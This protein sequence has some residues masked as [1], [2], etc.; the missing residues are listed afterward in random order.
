V[1]HYAL[2]VA[3]QIVAFCLSALAGRT[4]FYWW[5]R[6]GEQDRARVWRLYGWFSALMMFGCC[7]GALNWAS[8]IMFQENI[9]KGDDTSY[10]SNQVE[11]LTL[12][13]LAHRWRAANHMM[14]AIEFLCLCAAE[15][16]VLDRM[17]VFAAPGDV[18][19]QKRWAAAGRVVMAVAVLGNAVG[20]AANA[21]AAVHLQKA[22]AAESTAASYFAANNTDKGNESSSSASKELQLGGSFA[23]VQRF[24]EFAVLLLIV[25]AFVVVGVLC[26]RRVKSRLLGVDAASAAAA[27]GRAL[28]LQMVG[29]TAVVFAAFF[30]R[31][32]FSTFVAVAYASRD[33]GKEVDSR[34]LEADGPCHASCYNVYTQIVR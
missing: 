14:Y 9:F 27:T 5:R 29:T 34:C 31:S 10:S 22:A 11:R 1:T 4:M 21:A 18:D 26:A 16:M 3:E 19:M 28:R 15:L 2:T 23:S 7:I 6:V 12:R 24:C 17:S 13:A 33:V 32:V 20:L 30:I 8:R 25:V